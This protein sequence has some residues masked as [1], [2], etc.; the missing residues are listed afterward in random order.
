MKRDSFYNSIY[1]LRIWRDGDGDSF[2]PWRF[3]V[4]DTVTGER[5]GFTGCAEVAGFIKT[6]VE[7]S[8]QRNGKPVG[9][10]G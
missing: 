7:A 6:R 5:H 10:S 4:E 3:A 2:S 8:L 1:I 9:E